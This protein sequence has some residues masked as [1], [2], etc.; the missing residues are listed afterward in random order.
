MKN[1]IYVYRVDPI[2]DLHLWMSPGD[3]FN[4]TAT[5]DFRSYDEYEE[6]FNEGKITARFIGWEGDMR[7]GPVV[8]MLPPIGAGENSLFLIAWK[9]DN[10]GESFV[11]SPYELPWLETENSVVVRCDIERRPGEMKITRK[12]QRVRFKG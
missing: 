2:D 5:D 7:E 3:V 12:I 11:V 1:T 4:K 9:Q 6:V 10:N 8:S